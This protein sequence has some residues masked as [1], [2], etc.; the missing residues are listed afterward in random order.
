MVIRLAVGPAIALEEVSRPKFLVAMR[1]REVLRMPGP[2]QRGYNLEE[3]SVQTLN[4][5]LQI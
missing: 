2:T 3:A 4:L 1:A 5:V